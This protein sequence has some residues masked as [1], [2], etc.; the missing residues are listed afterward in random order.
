M[1]SVPDHVFAAFISSSFLY[2]DN[3]LKLGD[4]L[5]LCFG[6]LL[7]RHSR[8][9]LLNRAIFQ[10][11][12]HLY[13]VI[14]GLFEQPIGRA[15]QETAVVALLEAGKKMEVLDVEGHGHEVIRTE[16]SQR[17]CVL[18]EGLHVSADGFAE[19][20]KGAES[21]EEGQQ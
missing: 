20:A 10:V 1:E 17:Q 5:F 4:E 11:D 9:L 15:D 18:S 7:P 13:P 16:G 2:L 12:Q 21:W 19:D 6:E 8:L 3:L 14:I